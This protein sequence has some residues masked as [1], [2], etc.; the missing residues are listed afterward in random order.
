[1]PNVGVYIPDALD[2]RVRRL[3]ELGVEV[4]VSAICQRCLETS[5][6]AEEKAIK[7]DRMARLIA[8]V[9]RTRTA[10]EQA[11]ADGEGAGRRWA[12]DVAARSEMEAVRVLDAEFRGNPG[13]DLVNI[14]I[15]KDDGLV[16]AMFTSDTGAVPAAALPASVPLDFFEGLADPQASRF[17]YQVFRAFLR[18]ASAVL[19]ELDAA[20]KTQKMLDM[21]TD[22]AT[23]PFFLTANQQQ[24][25][26]RSS[27][28]KPEG[29]EPSTGK[30]G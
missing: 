6:E 28:P 5:V 19:S 14:W 3:K 25:R 12:E 29:D 2:Q 16:H 26:P 17:A 4:P 10:E 22:A 9:Q 8:R 30:K 23:R 24:R 11:V 20:L 27:K 18:G 7:G 13:L 21:M 1:M 15:D